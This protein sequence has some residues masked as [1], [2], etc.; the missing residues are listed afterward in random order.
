MIRFVSIAGESSQ[1]SAVVTP[2]ARG[3]DSPSTHATEVSLLP[4][5]LYSF[6]YECGGAPRR[7][8][9]RIVDCRHVAAGTPAVDELCSF[10]VYECRARGSNLVPTAPTA[11]PPAS[12]PPPLPTA[13]PT[14]PGRADPLTG[15][16][17]MSLTG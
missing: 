17:T 2:I 4:L 15:P 5:E 9:D 16:P 7:S 1:R 3:H 13:L 6:G 11:L 10:L 14:A 12:P 8:C